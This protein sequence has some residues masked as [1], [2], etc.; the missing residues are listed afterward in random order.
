MKVRRSARLVDMTR[1]LLQNPR[2]LVSLTLFT[3]R[4][5]SAKSSISEDLG[6]IKQ[7]F[8]ENGIGT[9]Q[10]VSGAAGGVSYIPYAS[11]EEIDEM[12]EGVCHLLEDSN[13]ILPGGYL[14]MTDIL[15]NPRYINVVGRIFSSIFI[16]KKVDVV[17]TVETKGIP[18]AY[19]V[20]NYLDVPVVIV[21]RNS[22]ITEGTTVSINYASG[23]T[24]SIETMLLAK[25][26]LPEGSN[27][28]IIDDFMRAGGT[29]A[30]MIQMVEE[31][32]AN[33]AGIG[34]FVESAV[35]D[36]RL[37][38]DFTSLISVSE[39]DT[40]E[41]K[42]SVERGNFHLTREYSVKEDVGL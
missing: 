30:G 11:E 24:K 10:T 14:Y 15:S 32:K 34:V 26:S 8:E 9:L 36:E 1:Y 40:K 28:L 23:S 2:R 42:V 27:V 31:F 3:K 20:A 7:T 6:I 22:I 38:T 18:L 12:M 5:G 4:Y 25:R 29:I 33:V 37:I 39:V 16:H 41:K 35:S 19:A 17:M 21:R 13:R